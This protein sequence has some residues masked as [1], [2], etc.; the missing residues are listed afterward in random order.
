VRCL[1]DPCTFPWSVAGAKDLS[2]AASQIFANL[3]NEVFLRAVSLWELSVKYAL[4]KLPLPGTFD[5]FVVEERERHGIAALP[6]NE[7]AVLH[8]HTLPLLHR[9]PFDHML[10]CQAIEH[11]CVLLTPDPLIAQY[12]VRKRWYVCT[13]ACSVSTGTQGYDFC[14][15]RR[16]HSV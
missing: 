5:C 13:S 2:P 1:L 10:I 14:V 12:P 15:F 6:L 3:A 11:G 9:D 16:A 7:P 4:G 8:L